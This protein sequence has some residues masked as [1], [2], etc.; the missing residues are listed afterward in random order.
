MADTAVL[1][2]R[3]FVCR[4]QRDSHII[5]GSDHKQSG[6]IQT[7]NAQ[8]G[9]AGEGGSERRPNTGLV[10]DALADRACIQAAEMFGYSNLPAKNPESVKAWFYGKLLLAALSETLVNTG[11]FSPSGG[12]GRRGRTSAFP[13][14]A[15]ILNENGSLN[16]AFSVLH[17]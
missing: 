7:N 15:K 11:R 13:M 17:K 12:N 3:E 14:F 9:L 2:G 16:Y 8:R 4:N 10:P 5:R 1:D 6:G